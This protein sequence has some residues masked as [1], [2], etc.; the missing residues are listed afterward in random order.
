M[1]V[2]VTERLE[3]NKFTDSDDVFIYR[4]LNTPG[5]L[6]FIGSRNINNSQDALDYIRN[7]V[8]VS[9]TKNGFGFYKITV[10]NSGKDIGMCGLIK[11]DGLEDP[12]L[13]FALLPEFGK[14]GYAREAAAAVL[15]YS[16]DTLKIKRVAAI[17]SKNNTAS[18]KLLET[19]GMTYRKN[20][21]LPGDSE[22]L[23][24]FTL[25]F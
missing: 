9:Y 16:R 23:F 19:L 11:R 22:E 15:E 2:I 10:S 13:G 6:K 5:W 7:K 14:K 20:I 24:Y 21:T 18:I 17:T 4:L 3:L 1:N 8:A 25:N 12:D